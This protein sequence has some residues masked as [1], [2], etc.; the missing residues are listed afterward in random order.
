MG[1]P[2]ASL[3]ATV[4]RYN[5][6]VAKGNDDDF[7]KRPEILWPVDTPPFYAGQLISTLL[8]ANGGLRQDTSARVLD[9]DNK[10]IEGLYVCGAAGG[11]Y[12]S[13]DYPTINPGTN[14]GRC[15]TFGHIAGINAAGGNS[16]AEIPDLAIITQ[17]MP[18]TYRI[19]TVTPSF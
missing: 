18:A 13:N 2:A 7:G 19:N 3:N 11:Q 17:Q 1:V 4:A 12:F 5:E 14:H 8:A 16:E 15:L 6:L 9:G 10:V